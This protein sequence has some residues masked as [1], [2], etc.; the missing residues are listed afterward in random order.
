MKKIIINSLKLGTSK[1]PKLKK[2]ITNEIIS[3]SV[4]YTKACK[5]I[6][7]SL[8]PWIK[9]VLFLNYKESEEYSTSVD[10]CIFIKSKNEQKLHI[11]GKISTII[12]SDSYDHSLRQNNGVT[13]MISPKMDRK[14]TA[15]W[16]FLL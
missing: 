13:Q 1:L 9:T 14:Q 2:N 4:E 15:S 6:L 16:F 11:E 8:Y 12:L 7:N 3:D 5:I 10:Y